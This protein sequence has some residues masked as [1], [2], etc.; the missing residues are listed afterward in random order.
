MIDVSP[1]AVNDS[2]SDSSRS[3]SVASR[4]VEVE[5]IEELDVVGVVGDA[6]SGRLLLWNRFCWNV[7]VLLL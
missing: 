4:E 1:N 7:T 3:V 2:L 5:G 6:R